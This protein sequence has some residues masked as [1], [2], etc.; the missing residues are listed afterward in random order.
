MAPTAKTIDTF[1]ITKTFSPRPHKIGAEIELMRRAEGAVLGHI[2]E[3]TGWLPHSAS[4]VLNG[5]RKKN[6]YP[7]TAMRRDDTCYRIDEPA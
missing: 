6:Y 5:S 4:A 3:A 7:E 1:A 2:L